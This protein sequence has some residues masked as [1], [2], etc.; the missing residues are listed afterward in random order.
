[1]PPNELRNVDFPLDYRAFSK[2]Q[3][4]NSLTTVAG[5]TLSESKHNKL[6]ECNTIT[7]LLDGPC[8][9]SQTIVIFW[10]FGVKKT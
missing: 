4:Q 9:N 10:K 6:N 7:H 3:S 8:Q 2:M 1:M 5:W